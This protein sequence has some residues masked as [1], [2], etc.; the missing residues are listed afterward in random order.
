MDIEWVIE[1]LSAQWRILMSAAEVFGI[2]TA[3]AL[4]MGWGAASLILH[5]RLV[6]QKERLRDC[7]GQMMRL[8]QNLS[9]AP[10]GDQFDRSELRLSIPAGD[11]EP[12]V[13]FYIN[14]FK[15]HLLRQKP[16]GSDKGTEP[17]T[18]TILLIAF[19]QPTSGQRLE[20][21]SDSVLPPHQ[22]KEFNQR[23]AIIAFSGPI[24]ACVLEIIA[25]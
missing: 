11:E 23:F 20:V 2:V 4:L 12:L 10:A 6:H 21:K 5:K 16:I 25:R 19:N 13:L 9:A 8:Q 7:E 24:P 14:V 1:M 18:E 17:K 3:L 22:V 15:W